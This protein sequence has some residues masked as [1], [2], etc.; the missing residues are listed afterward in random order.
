MKKNLI[1]ILILTVGTVA[2][3][4]IYVNKQK[5]DQLMAE[6]HQA[7]ENGRYVDAFEMYNE[8]SKKGVDAAHYW[9]AYM[10]VLGLGTS[11]NRNLAMEE[12]KQIKH[13][14]TDRSCLVGNNLIALNIAGLVRDI[15]RVASTE[16][17]DWWKQEARRNGFD[18]QKCSKYYED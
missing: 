11:E 17:V 9:L 18:D 12:L 6:A 2:V 15:A 7:L 1:I 10:Y 8:I 14:P 5:N 4:R 13:L 3:I 16:T